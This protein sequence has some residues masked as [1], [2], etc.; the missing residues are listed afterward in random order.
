MQDKLDLHDMLS[1]LESSPFQERTA[2]IDSSA[3]IL[4]PGCGGVEVRFVENK[5][6]ITRKHQGLT[7]SIRCNGPAPS[8]TVADLCG[9]V[10]DAINE[11]PEDRYV[12]ITC[13]TPDEFL[14]SF[15]GSVYLE[16]RGE[17]G[18]FFLNGFADRFS[19]DMSSGYVP[20]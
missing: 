20:A 11:Y 7:L 13:R 2:V 19:Y 14:G 6:L 3:G 18:H 8:Y 4:L 17:P 12:S 9:I 15:D 10:A 1:C 16:E 5:T